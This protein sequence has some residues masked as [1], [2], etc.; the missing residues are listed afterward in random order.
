[1]KDILITLDNCKPIFDESFIGINRENLQKN[2]IFAF[3]GAFV[4]GV[5]NLE[6]KIDDE[7]GVIANLEKVNDTYVL[8]IR[9][10]LLTSDKILMQ[11]VIY[12]DE[13]NEETPI[14]KSEIIYLKVKESLNATG[15]IPD[16]YPTWTETLGALY[17]EVQA[18]MQETET[19]L[20]NIPTKTSQLT[21][22]SG[23]IT[24][25]VDNLEYY[26]KTGVMNNAI[27]NAVSN[28]ATL[29]QNADNNLQ[30]QIDAITSASD[31][32]DVVGTYQDLLDYD[33]S[34]LTDNDIIKVLDDSTHDNATSYYRWNNN[35]WTYI[36]SEG[37]FY[38]KAETDALLN[39][40]QDKIDSS[41]KLSS[42]LVDDTGHTNKFATAEQLAQIGTNAS[43]ISDIQTALNGKEDKA[44]KVTS[45]SASSTD[46]E[47]P[48]AKCVYDS[49]VAQDN[50]TNTINN[51]VEYYATIMNALP[52][53]S[54]ENT[55][56]AL[57]NTAN[58]PMS[59]V[60]KPSTLE[61]TTTTG[62]NLQKFTPRTSSTSGA[63]YTCTNEGQVIITG[64]QTSTE[65]TYGY[66]TPT[67]DPM[68]LT[69]GTYTAKLIGTIDNNTKIVKEGGAILTFDENNEST[70]TLSA[71]TTT[72]RLSTYMT[73]GE[74]NS[75]FRLTLASGTTATTERYTGGMPSPN[76]D[77][78]QDIHTIS[79]DNTININSK[80][81]LNIQSCEKGF[82][83]TTGTVAGASNVTE[84]YVTDNSISF[85]TNAIN[86][87]FVTDFIKVESDKYKLT[88]DKSNNNEMVGFIGYYDE[89]KNW[90]ERRNLSSN[91][92]I[93]PSN[94]KYFKINLQL[95]WAGSITLSNIQLEKGQTGT[96]YVPYGLQTFPIT[97]GELEYCKIGD[98]AD[99]FIK[100]TNETGLTAGKWYLKK[101][102][103]H[104]SLAIADMNNEDTYPGWK[105]QTYLLTDYPSY[106]GPLYNKANFKCNILGANQ[107]GIQINSNYAN[108]VMYLANQVFGLTQTQWITNYP[109]LVFEVIYTLA[110]TP[111]YILLNNTLQ[112]ELENIYNY[113][114][115]YKDQTNITQTNTDLPFVI[116][117]SATKDLSNI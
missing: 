113:A 32:V 51:K 41:H 44:N 61:Q 40:K 3:K 6:I 71:D 23:F 21:N 102:T 19:A 98:Y 110:N 79:G 63:T 42:D 90:I 16:E 62:A 88:Y 59:I 83:G 5:A 38:T 11:L 53:V 45:I 46:T 60:L 7:E 107:Q 111:E 68:T 12:Q 69:A 87:G 116:S 115:G 36:G 93:I 28:E 4:E 10:S 66:N 74:H 13:I 29:R 27:Y 34:S 109:N 52:K 14:Y 1:M 22:D 81:Y 78:P 50:I 30:S 104:I 99:E 92:E 117:A 76:P 39:N 57:N 85:T 65:I 100:A 91:Y 25:D 73:A 97:L 43:N 31:V 55:E 26:S 54:G 64:T 101:N 72:F 33:T 67:S 106:N 58:S 89:N 105:N 80:N 8:P 75:N 24:K 77:Y 49:Q 95:R 17:L 86:R 114:L 56:L 2:L 9:D 96:T 70:F 15:T 103:R 18:L 108:G 48:S 84:Y 35:S 37:S 47:Y 112:E 94:V 82:L 20:E